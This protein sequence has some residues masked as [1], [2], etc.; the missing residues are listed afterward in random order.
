MLGVF[1]FLMLVG[2]SSQ[3]PMYMVG[4]TPYQINLDM[5]MS[6]KTLNN[7]CDALKDIRGMSNYKY[8]TFKNIA[9]AIEL[10]FE[11]RGYDKRYCTDPDYY[12]YIAKNEI[13][14]Y[15][16][17]GLTIVTSSKK[18][19]SCA[20][21][22][23]HMVSIDGAIG[24]DSSF[25]LESI[26]SDLESCTDSQGEVISRTVVELNSNGGSLYD[27]YKLGRLLRSYNVT[28]IVRDGSRCASSCAVAFLGGVKRDVES[29]GVILFHSPYY[30]QAKNNIIA[31]DVPQEALRD[32]QLY[33]IEMVGSENADRLYDR[34]MSYCSSKDGWEVI[35]SNASKLYGISN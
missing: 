17:D 19:H 10:E 25:A 14:G 23:V 33:Y 24:P 4:K 9:A 12:D 2:C 35:G 32:L 29:N 16:I 15:H 11:N 27:G 18:M 26:L 13:N 30:V 22:G 34:T 1:S 8:E 20:Y 6:D 3:A 7:L 28:S 21:G 5:K 31:C